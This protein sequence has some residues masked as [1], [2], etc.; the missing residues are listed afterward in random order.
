MRQDLKAARKESADVLELIGKKKLSAGERKKV[1]KE[2]VKY[3]SDHVNA[4][5]LKYRKSVSTD[6]TAV[7]WEDDGAVF[8]DI[9]G[10]EFLDMLGGFGV[11]VTGHRHPKVLKA[12]IDQ[13]N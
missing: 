4:G 5:F 13:L 7:E 3:W 11:Y 2:S 12:V 1:V 10:K 9:N 8:R 6:Y